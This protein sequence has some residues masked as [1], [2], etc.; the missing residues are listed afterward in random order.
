MTDHWSDSLPRGES[1]GVFN[2][3]LNSEPIRSAA[4]TTLLSTN[5]SCVT[6]L[7]YLV[8]DVVPRPASLLFTPIF[9]GGTGVSNALSGSVVGII[10][11]CGSRFFCVASFPC[12]NYR[13]ARFKLER[14][15]L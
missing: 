10:N 12:L 14:R 4:L 13:F 6:A 8:Q 11:R 1:Q 7:I 2:Y 15:W 9:S 3:D 5:S